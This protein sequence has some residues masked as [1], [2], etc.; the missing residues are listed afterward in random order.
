MIC[1][2]VWVIHAVRTSEQLTMLLTSTQLHSRGGRENV[3]KKQNKRFRSNSATPIDIKSLLYLII[4]LLLHL[5]LICMQLMLVPTHT[6]TVLVGKKYWIT[7]FQL[8]V[9]L[10]QIRK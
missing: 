9:L 2:T 4:E 5:M 3:F 1:Q 10:N 6:Y 7:I 8:L